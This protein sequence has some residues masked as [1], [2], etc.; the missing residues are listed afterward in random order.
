MKAK[1]S[2]ITNTSIPMWTLKKQRRREIT[3]HN[4]DRVDKPRQTTSPTYKATAYRLCARFSDATKTNPPHKHW[5]RTG[6]GG[7]S[8]AQ[9]HNIRD[10]SER[11]SDTGYVIEKGT[12][13]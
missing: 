7:C 2:A 12:E 4:W 13:G 11:E 5:H 6:N 3:Q 9:V 8:D 10:R 1:R